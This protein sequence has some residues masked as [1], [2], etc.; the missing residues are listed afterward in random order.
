VAE[1]PYMFKHIAQELRD[2]AQWLC[3]RM[4][5]LLRG[6]GHETNSWRFDAE[7]RENTFTDRG[8]VQ[9]I[10]EFFYEKG[11]DRRRILFLGPSFLAQED[12]P[13]DVPL[14]ALMR[15]KIVRYF[16]REILDAN[17]ALAA[18]MD[19][20][21][22]LGHGLLPWRVFGHQSDLMCLLSGEQV[23]KALDFP[24][25][26]VL[27]R[28]CYVHLVDDGSGHAKR[29]AGVAS[30]KV[31]DRGERVSWIDPA[32]HVNSRPRL[33]H[34]IASSVEKAQQMFLHS[35]YMKDGHG[36]PTPPGLIVLV[37]PDELAIEEESQFPDPVV[38]PET[39]VMWANF[40]SNILLHDTTVLIV[41]EISGLEDYPVSVPPLV[42]PWRAVAKFERVYRR[43]T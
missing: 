35:M 24:I 29:A 2:E 42:E 22:I 3:E 37:C 15:P 40:L 31:M 41:T 13:R 34:H 36:N 27:P 30:K 21:D 17:A 7:K 10:I 12:T 9:V 6:S 5:G 32:R 14:A 1:L 4:Q 23:P 20:G 25:E 33:S 11:D 26:D 28:G 18:A 19:S 39:A 16:F 8:T 43:T 38:G